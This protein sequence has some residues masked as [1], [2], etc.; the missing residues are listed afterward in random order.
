M[1]G[2]WRQLARSGRNASGWNIAWSEQ[3]PGARVQASDQVGHASLCRCGLGP[4]LKE[5]GRTEQWTGSVRCTVLSNYL[6]TI[7]IL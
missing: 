2:T 1:R 3:R 5:L 7:Q 6:K 4:D